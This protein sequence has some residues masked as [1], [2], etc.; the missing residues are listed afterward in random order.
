M[1]ISDVVALQTIQSLWGNRIRDRVVQTFDSTGEAET[2][3]AALPEGA[4]C[5]IPSIRQVF[6]K[7][8]NIWTPIA[9]LTYTGAILYGGNID[10]PLVQTTARLVIPAGFRSAMINYR[11]FAVTADQVSVSTAEAKLYTANGGTQVAG[12]AVSNNP[13]ATIVV[14]VLATVNPLGDTIVATL[15]NPGGASFSVFNDGQNHQ[16]SAIA[17]P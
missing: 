4:M 15:G 14:P 11:V 9:P 2:N 6:V 7:L 17:F 1:W 16:L 5:S 8:A 12:T 13:R 3:K 10:Q